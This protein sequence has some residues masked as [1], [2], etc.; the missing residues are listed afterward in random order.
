MI[1]LIN[2]DVA[3]LILREKRM[4]AYFT[5]RRCDHRSGEKN[6]WVFS[7]ISCC[8]ARYPKRRRSQ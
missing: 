4:G 3:G 6:K 1:F 2:D 7:L 8:S 5:F